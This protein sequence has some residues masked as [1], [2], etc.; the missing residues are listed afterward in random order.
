MG[1]L[2][3]MELPGRLIDPEW[4]RAQL[5]SGQPAEDLAVA[6]VRW[7]PDGHARDGFELGHV[8][9]AVCVDVDADLAAPPFHGPGRHPLPDPAAFAATMSRLGIGDGR[10]VVA[11]DDVGGWVAARLWWMLWSLGHAAGV[12]D[13]PTLD[14]WRLAGGTLETGPANP[15]HVASFSPAEWPKARLADARDVRN[16]LRDGSAVVVDARA[17]ERYRG[18]TEPF[19][20]VAGHVPGAVSGPWAGNLDADGRLLPPP[21]LRRRFEALGLDGRTDAIAMCGSG[22]TASAVVF[23]TELAGLGPARLYEG[24]WS[25]WV[26]DPARPVATGP[27]RGRLS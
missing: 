25:D 17:A 27:D 22:I 2:A 15:R 23:A 19:D 12:L 26:S 13:L 11:Y 8:P 5:S 18:E 1:I 20:P 16:G 24:S 6:D 4:L 9:G 7:V 3:R 21:E 10:A 14:A